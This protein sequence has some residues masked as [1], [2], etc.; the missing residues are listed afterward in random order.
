MLILKECWLAV[1]KGNKIELVFVNA[2]DNK[3]A[4]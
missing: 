2:G 3:I 4:D 1:P